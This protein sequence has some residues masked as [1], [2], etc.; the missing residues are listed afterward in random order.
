M[1]V[2]RLNPKP[3][4]VPD[5]ILV[6]STEFR[7]LSAYVPGAGELFF[8]ADAFNDPVANSLDAFVVI[9]GVDRFE[10]LEGLLVRFALCPTEICIPKR[11]AGFHDPFHGRGYCRP[12]YLYP[13]GSWR[14]ERFLVCLRYQFLDTVAPLDRFDLALA[15]CRD[16]FG[17]RGRECQLFKRRLKIRQFLRDHRWFSFVAALQFRGRRA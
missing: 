13:D 16:D 3:L 7:R 10:F 1:L 8:V 12:L 5:L 6:R 15:D 14:V 4:V 2:A 17:P 11:L 9:I